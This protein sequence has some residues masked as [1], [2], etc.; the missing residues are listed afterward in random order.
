MN[1]GN[2]VNP[3]QVKPC[4]LWVKNLLLCVKYQSLFRKHE[5]VTRIRAH[6]QFP[7]SGSI[8]LTIGSPRLDVQMTRDFISRE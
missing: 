1:L 2:A 4:C 5:S 8:A 6:R 7:S 3:E